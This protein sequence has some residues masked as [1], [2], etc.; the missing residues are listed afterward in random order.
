MVMV[1]DRLQCSR[2]YVQDHRAE[3]GA[4][5]LGGLLRFSPA[6]VEAF[7]GRGAVSTTAP[8]TESEPTPIRQPIDTTGLPAT[9]PVTGERWS[10]NR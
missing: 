3:L 7:V 4:R 8:S 1:M 10:W 2:S 6:D 9:N 5:K